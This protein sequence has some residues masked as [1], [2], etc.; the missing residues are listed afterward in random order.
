MIGENDGAEENKRESK[1]Y[2]QTA[3]S[4]TDTFLELTL[5]EEPD[6][7][8]CTFFSSHDNINKEKNNENNEKEKLSSNDKITSNNSTLDYGTETK[9]LNAITIDAELL[10]SS[11]HQKPRPDDQEEHE[12]EESDM[13]AEIDDALDEG[14]FVMLFT[15]IIYKEIRVNFKLPY[16]E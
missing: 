12:N 11:P 5:D 1:E 3:N 10:E 15:L 9:G 14:Y 2:K 16:Y 8:K 4:T 6:N 13:D 7:N